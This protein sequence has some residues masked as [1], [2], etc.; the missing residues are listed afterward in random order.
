MALELKKKSKIYLKSQKVGIEDNSPESAE[1][2]G[3]VDFPKYL[4][5]GKNSFKIRPVDGAFLPNTKIEIEVLDSNEKPIYWEIPKYKE[6]DKGRLIS[7]W[8]YDLPENRNYNTPNGTAQII[9]LGTLPNGNLVRWSRKIDV[10]KS[11]KS[12]SNIVFNSTLLPRV[13][14]S[15]SIETFT[16]KKVSNSKLT[17][18]IAN[19][20]VYYKKST[21]G[22][23][24]TLEYDALSNFNT[25][26]VGGTVYTVNIPTLF[27]RL[28][29]G[30]SQPTQFTAS[31]TEVASSTIMRINTPIT[32]SDNR[33]DG[34]IH[35]YEYSD[36]TLEV[37]IEYYS[38]GSDTSTQN[39]I[40]FANF[41][42]TNVKPIVGRIDSINTLIKSQ[43][44]TNADYELIGN[45][46][47]ENTS[48]LSYKVP[49]PTEH[50]KDPKSL[51]LQFLNSVG[52]I[53]STE[54]VVENIVFDGGNVYIA[55][56]QSLISGSFHIG[57]AI[58]TGIELAGN[59]SGYLKSVGYYG[60]TSASLG[61]G[62][63]GFLMWSG[64][65]NLVVGADTYNGVGLDLVAN[66]ESYF[67]YT[68][69]GGGNLDIRTD[70]FFIGNP[71]NQFISGAN[72]SIEISSSLF[73]LDPE[74][75]L[76]V[77]GADAV[78]NA[79]LSA[80]QIFTPATIGGSPSTIL[81]ASASI[82]SDGFAKF[83]SASIAGFEVSTTQ[84][85]SSNDALILKANGQITGSAVRIAV[86]IGGTEYEVLD[87]AKGIV[88]AKNVGRS[89]YF[90]SDEISVSK[91][92]GSTGYTYASPLYVVW[93][94]LK[95]ETRVNVS[96]Q[97]LIQK[98]GSCRAIGGIKATLQTATSGSST[99]ANSYYDSWT[100]LR[101][102]NNIGTIGTIGVSTTYTGS[103][104]KV[105][106][107]AYTFEIDD[108][109]DGLNTY[110]H[111]QYQSQLFRLKLEPFAQ[112]GFSGTGT[113]NVFVK[114]ISVWTSR[115]IAST[116]EVL[117]EVPGGGGFGG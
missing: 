2:F 64:S 67:R 65:G 101:T 115:G 108:Y 28:G 29:G 114:N 50:L 48:S 54:L 117:P 103:A 34:S 53:S 111:A 18:T 16:N 75:N 14:V 110:N 42:L 80:D 77:I 84:I 83:V 56:D 22:D 78:I 58:G 27:P 45:T 25:E 102:V 3:V 92:G 37:N 4:G 73:H 76:L 85:N 21:F 5:E 38:T 106:G 43:G 57:N 86:D 62:P 9:L 30:Q 105:S 20:E 44:L 40:A 1:F 82:T 98:D 47:V 87:T 15:S 26:M 24:T 46:K 113:A 89:L 97:G 88:D 93:Q 100:N 116:F 74:N 52:E 33:S 96:F 71:N 81:N 12:V 55:G 61:K 13:N 35:T 8:I 59:S 60:F 36:G 66:A 39:Q 32:A 69:D 19:S 51:K 68:T 90:N 79:S 63:G 10:N 23:T 104:S 107:D 11:R 6:E 41:T 94:G 17:K 72:S 95:Y 49:I 7:V 70:S 109:V 112:I 31:I 91:S 99:S